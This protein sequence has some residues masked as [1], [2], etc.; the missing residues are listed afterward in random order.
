M[1]LPPLDLLNEIAGEHD[2]T[3]GFTPRLIACRARLLNQLIPPGDVLDLGC[4]D[5]HLAGELR[6][7]GH[8]VVGV[9]LVATDGVED[10]VDELV[11]A[12][13]DHGLRPR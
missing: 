12:D 3:R 2:Q 6:A 5:G 8:H 1:A 4:A 10:R 11:R 13:L 7:A 9:D